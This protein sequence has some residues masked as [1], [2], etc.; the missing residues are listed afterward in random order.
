MVESMTVHTGTVHS[1]RG[2][3]VTRTSVLE[4]NVAVTLALIG[5]VCC[6]VCVCEVKCSDGVDSLGMAHTV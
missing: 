6:G 3:T 4:P 5:D 2:A 1:R